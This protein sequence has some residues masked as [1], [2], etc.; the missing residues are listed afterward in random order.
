MKKLGFVF[1]VNPNANI[2]RPTKY[3]KNRIPFLLK[4]YLPFLNEIILS[5]KVIIYNRNLE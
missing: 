4:N 2:K 5:K 3:N 1:K